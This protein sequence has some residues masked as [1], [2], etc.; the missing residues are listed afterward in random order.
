MK[1]AMLNLQKLFDQLM[2]QSEFLNEGN[3]YRKS[4][5][6]N[7]EGTNMQYKAW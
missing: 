3:E 4:C 1:T 7:G 6:K 2:R 5:H